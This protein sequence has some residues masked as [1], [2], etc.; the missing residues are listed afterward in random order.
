MN[1]RAKR[2]R[3]LC[4]LL[5]ESKGPFG[6]GFALLSGEHIRLIQAESI[7]GSQGQKTRKIHGLG[8]ALMQAWIGLAHQQKTVEI[9]EGHGSGLLPSF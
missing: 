5:L 9:G 7:V 1:E 4:L 2:P 8:Q 6:L 3:L